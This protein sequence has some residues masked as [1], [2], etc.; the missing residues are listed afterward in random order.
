MILNPNG[1]RIDLEKAREEE[2]KKEQKKKD[3][4]KLRIKVNPVQEFVSSKTQ[5]GERPKNPYENS[6]VTLK[7]GIK[8]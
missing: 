5:P 1:K 3:M 6:N 4:D 2:L 7:I 8:R